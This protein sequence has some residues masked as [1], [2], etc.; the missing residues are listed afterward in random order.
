[1]RGTIAL[2]ALGGLLGLGG[3][4]N[5]RVDTPEWFAQR[6]A[7]NDDAYPSL[8]SVPRTNDAETDQTHWNAVEAEMLAAGQAVRTNPRSEP[9]TQV[10]APEEFLEEAQQDLEQARQ[11]HQP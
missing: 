1:M 2:A 6:S 8:H 11:S 9:A 4:I 10:Q 7:E 5:T 3:C